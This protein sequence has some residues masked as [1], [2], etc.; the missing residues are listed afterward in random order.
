MPT[1]S[2]EQYLL[3][4]LNEARL[5]PLGNA[6]RYISSYSPLNSSDANIAQALSFYN[7][8]G[9]ALLAALRALPA[10]GALAWNDS[11]ATAAERHSAAMIAANEQS[12]QVKGEADLSTRV[13]T[14]GYTG[15]KALG[16]NVYGY[17]FSPQY[18]HAAFMV[19]WGEG[20]NGM[21]SPAGHRNNIMSTAYTE[22]GID[23]TAE[24]NEKTKIGPNVVTED[25]GSRGKYYITGVAFTDGD[26]NSFYTI[27]EGVQGLNVSVGNASTTSGVSGGYN[28]EVPTGS[29]VITLSGGALTGILTV[30]TTITN[31]NL[32]LDVVNSSTLLTSGSISVLSG[33]VSIVKLISVKGATITTGAGNQDIRGN[34]GNDVIIAGAGN[35]KLTGG[36]GNDELYGGDGNDEL[37]GGAGDDII[38]GGG[39]TDTAHFTGL[40]SSYT[41]SN[42]TGGG[43]SITGPLTGTDLV[44]NV[45]FFM[46]D[47]GQFTLAQMGGTANFAPTLTTSQSITTSAGA[48]KQLTVAAVDPDGD[49]LTY[50]ASA[51]G[52]GTI[53]KGGTDGVF[54]YTPNAGFSGS[55][56]FRVT[57][58]DGRGGTSFQNVQVTVKAANSAPT[59]ATTQA[60]ATAQDAAKQVTV[61]ASDVDGDTLTYSAGA[62][63]HGVVTGGANGVFTYKPTKGYYGA[64]SFVVTVSDGQGGTVTQTVKVD[65]SYVAPPL[66][67][68][69]S[70]STQPFKLFAVDGLADGVGGTGTVMGTNA[71]QDVRL[72]DSPG[73]IT[74]DSSF[75]KGGDVIRLSHAA[76]FYKITFTGSNAQI[77]G[78]GAT[79]LISLGATG[80]VL[81]FTDGARKL[82]FD[83][84]DKVGKIGS[85]TITD[86]AVQITAPT[87]GTP[88]PG[89]S[90][91]AAKGNVFLSS[92]ADVLIDGNHTVFG[93]ATTSETVRYHGGTLVLDSS[94]NKGG[95]TLHLNDAAAD[96]RAYI[97]GS[98]VVLV[99][100]EGTVTIPVGSVGLKLDFDGDERIIKFDPVAKQVLIG[101]QSITALTPAT[102]NGLDG[103][104]GVSLDVGTVTVPTVIELEAGTTYSLS[105]NANATGHVVIHGFDA[106]DVI[107]I[108]GAT[109]SDY[110]FSKIDYDNDGQADDVEITYNTNTVNNLIYLTNVISNQNVW[111]SDAT[112]A[113]QAVGSQ[114]IV[115]ASSPS[116]GSGGTPVEG[117]GTSL[118]VGSPSVAQVIQLAGQTNYT[119]TD[120]AAQS[121]NVVIHGFNAGDVIQV[122]GATSNDYNFSKLDYDQDGQADDIEITFSTGGVSNLIYL[123]DAV[124]NPNVFVSTLGSAESAIGSQFISFG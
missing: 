18:A 59:V 76:S 64:D 11:L 121:G 99:S 113:K 19:D 80:V 16:E 51:A 7:V 50:T 38:D 84:V 109:L 31:E 70:T 9:T 48:A 83:G 95:D 110:N 71:F 17:A 66:G 73:T 28:L 54:V 91:P 104:S 21:Q 12:H 45:E 90:N 47:D 69:G 8:D 98:T 15:F 123:I 111:V 93:I 35:D 29:N 5:N 86:V 97:S 74:F 56:S 40:R 96:F 108:S 62:A 106:G 22:V 81:N 58:S 77:T 117:T 33:P 27:G 119:L 6:L 52:N 78:G 2:E 10:A 20:A 14:A 124:A 102:A 82:Y 3:E 67:S 44:R 26:R 37:F 112:T 116:S 89:G 87:D 94:F 75:N 32:K 24:R 105:D 30:S 25:F 88:I 23:I 36:A 120:N 107:R 60:I 13:E 72:L 39:G 92:G 65:V 55:D 57:V 79:Y 100:A 49:K 63:G 43:I 1:T 46:F 118:D 115:D 122:N 4:L 85:Q 41:T 34:E 114:F 61:A 53:T 103:G 101:T 42:L 68:G